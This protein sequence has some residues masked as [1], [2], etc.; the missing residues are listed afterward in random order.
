[1]PRLAGLQARKGSSCCR[2]LGARATVSHLALCECVPGL[3]SG[4][5]ACMA[6]A[7]TCCAT[8]PIPILNITG[9]KVIGTILGTHPPYKVS[10]MSQTPILGKLLCVILLDDGLSNNPTGLPMALES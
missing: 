9:N 7:F 10:I 8:S 4:H 1:M 2:M 3:N 5:Q 6:T